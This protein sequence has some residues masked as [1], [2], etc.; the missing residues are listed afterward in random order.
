MP[1]EADHEKV[2]II[3][4]DKLN[5]GFYFMADPRALQQR[6]KFNVNHFYIFLVTGVLGLRGKFTNSLDIRFHFPP[7]EMPDNAPFLFS[8]L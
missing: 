7:V 4:F 1:H 5:Y 3:F 6:W 2:K 8:V